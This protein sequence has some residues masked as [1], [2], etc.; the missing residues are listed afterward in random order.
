MLQFANFIPLMQ[1]AAPSCGTYFYK[2]FDWANLQQPSL[3]AWFQNT[4]CNEDGLIPNSYNFYKYGFINNNF[5]YNMSDTITLTAALLC[6]VTVYSV[7]RLL[8][9]N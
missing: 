1:I 2:Q 6:I 8:L 3:G 7:I 9:P 4:V 5:M